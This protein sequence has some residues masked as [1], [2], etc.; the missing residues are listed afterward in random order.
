MS[1]N[2]DTSRSTFGYVMTYARGVVSWQSRLQKAV[3]LLTT[4][5]EYMVAAKA[6]K[7]IIWMKE[8]IGELGIRQ[9]ELQLHCD[10]QSAIH[11]ATNAAYHSRTKHI[12]RRYHWL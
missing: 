1:A 6:G 11:L 8:F 5:A 10:N 7:E 9:D 4:E 3:T 12:Q 2:V